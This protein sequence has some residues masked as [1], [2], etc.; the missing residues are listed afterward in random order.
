MLCT[1]GAGERHRRGIQLLREIDSVVNSIR[2]GQ[3][4]DLPAIVQ[5]LNGASL[6]TTDLPEAHEF[7]TWVLEEGG[8]LLGAIGLERFGNE[9]LLRSLIVAPRRRKCGVGHDLVTRLELD[10]QAEGIQHLILLTETAES[11]FRRLGYAVT[12]RGH[13]SDEIKQS[14]EFRS[15]CPVSAVC[16]SKALHP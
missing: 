4:G 6:P 13:V 7:Q 10:A 12:D 8:S 14:P 5:L 1:G 9:G 3:A 11:F 15:L 2:R 16:M